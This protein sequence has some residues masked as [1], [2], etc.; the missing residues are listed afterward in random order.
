MRMILKAQINLFYL[1]LLICLTALGITGCDTVEDG[2]IDIVKPP[3]AS[4]GDIGRRIE[5][6]S[7]DE[8]EGREPG[9]DGGRKAAQFIADEMKM[10]G[11]VPMGKNGSYFQP[12]ELTEAT[13]LPGSTLSISTA[14]DT[15]LQSDQN[16]NSVFWTK[17]LNETISIKD[18][19]L[20]FVGYGIVA[21]EYGWDDYAGLDV[22]GKTVIILVNDP[23][24]ETLDESLFKASA[25][26]YYGRWT[27]KFEEAGRQ[28]AAAALIVHETKPASYGWGVV[29]GSWSGPQYDLVR[30]DKGASRVQ[31]EGWLQKD[32]AQTIF[33]A[34]DMNFETA[35][36]A[37]LTQGFKPQPMAGLSLSATLNQRITT[38][39]SNNVAGGVIGTEYPDEYILYMGHWDHLGINAKIEGDNIWN[40]AVDNA[41][42][43]SVILEIGEA[44][45]EQGAPKRS[46]LILALTAE[47][48]GLL[49]S[50][51]YAEDPLIALEKTVAGINIDGMM[52]I[53]KT[54]DMIV[55][56]Y[57]ASQLEDRLDTVLKA[58]D[59]YI[60]PDPEPEAGYYYRS[61][62][63]SPV[64]YTHLTL[65][66]KA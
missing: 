17:R 21:P 46:V 22:K 38:V 49:G 57:G 13:V 50:A 5:R 14:D 40:G 7:S 54:K 19:E 33:T 1:L 12:V 48:S 30:P 24:F 63:I 36:T 18:S 6:L 9:T 56:G 2:K 65:P 53:G 10:A 55:I 26:T 34:A 39:K 20:V 66:T 32:A 59:M 23:G 42:G 15:V 4:A 45:A 29:S 35:K 43:I 60:A 8:F 64:S 41:T 62:H 51:Y 58:R 61:D 3:I 16:T 44:F 28:G 52:P 31:L 47:E 11:L 25:M 37:A 27:Y